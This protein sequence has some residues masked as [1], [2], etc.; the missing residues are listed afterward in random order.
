MI[1]GSGLAAITVVATNR[2]GPADAVVRRAPD[3]RTPC[4]FT[5][6]PGRR[7]V[8][9]T[10][11]AVTR[12][13][14][15][16]FHV[17]SIAVNGADVVTMQYDHDGML[18][19]AGAA[20]IERNGPGGAVTK[21]TVGNIQETR[22]YGSVFGDL[23]SIV[24][25]NTHGTP[26]TADDTQVASFTYPAYPHRDH[27]GRIV[28]RTESIAGGATSTFDYGYDLAGRLRDVSVNGTPM[29]VPTPAY[30]YDANGNRTKAPGVSAVTYDDQDRLLSTAP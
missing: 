5:T 10:P 18:I 6:V 29:A 26:S 9:S 3:P 25:L 7:T 19:Q 27:F 22:T 16:E 17:S 2:R 28:R 1:S 24:V 20:V 4:P 30:D 11:V 13:Y 14:N 15:A 12:T 21:V 8:L 23:E